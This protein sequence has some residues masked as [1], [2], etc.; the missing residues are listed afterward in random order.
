MGDT[1]GIFVPLAWAMLD[2]EIS[3]TFLFK[4]KELWVV[5]FAKAPVTKYS[6]PWLMVCY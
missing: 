5:Y 2:V 6:C 1:N 4:S 3:E